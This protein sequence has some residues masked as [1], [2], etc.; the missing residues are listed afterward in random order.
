MHPVK[1]ENIKEGQVANQLLARELSTEI[2]FTR[3]PDSVTRASVVKLVHYQMNPTP[4]WGP[5]KKATG[6]RKRE[7]E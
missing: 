4:N 5:A 2:N 3:H 6:K 1:M 7:E